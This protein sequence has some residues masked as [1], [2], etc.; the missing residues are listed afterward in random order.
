MRRACAAACWLCGTETPAQQPL[1]A[2]GQPHPLC[3][4]VHAPDP[5]TLTLLHGPPSTPPSAARAA[6][7]STTTPAWSRC[8]TCCDAAARSCLWPPTHWWGAGLGVCAF[9]LRACLL[10]RSGLGWHA[11][12][13]EPHPGA[14]PPPLQWDYT[15][16]VMN[17]VISRRKGEDRDLEWLKYFDAV[18]ELP[19]GQISRRCKDSDISTRR[20]C[21]HPAERC[22]L[23]PLSCWPPPPPPALPRPHPACNPPLLLQPAGGDG[24][25]QAALLH[26]AQQPV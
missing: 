24:L 21:V 16:V 15:N 10:A 12:Q 1:P 13:A 19:C 11:R 17:W 20:A 23:L 14:C 3:S 5:I 6:G 18:S 22:S 26:R 8:L 7:T 25:R 2:P 4:L 9:C